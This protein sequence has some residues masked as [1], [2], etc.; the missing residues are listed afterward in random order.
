MTPVRQ[1][2]SPQLQDSVMTLMTKD[3]YTPALMIGKYIV[4]HLDHFQFGWYNSL[5][6]QVSPMEKPNT[7]SLA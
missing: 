1:A 2:K 5:E 7:L 4:L 6:A 3:E